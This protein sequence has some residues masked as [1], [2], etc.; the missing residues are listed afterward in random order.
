[1]LIDCPPCYKPIIGCFFYVFSFTLTTTNNTASQVFL[2][3]YGWGNWDSEKS[4]EL[5]KATQVVKDR[6]KIQTRPKH[7]AHVLAGLQN[8]EDYMD[9]N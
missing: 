3:Y 5:P 4:D 8:C 7:N 1:M 2:L 9:K 6:T